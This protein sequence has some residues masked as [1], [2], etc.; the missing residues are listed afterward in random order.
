[1]KV[2][3]VCDDLIQFGGA[4]RVL[5]AV[6]EIWSDA[7]IYTSAAS[8]K[9]TRICKE[10]NID[11]RVS[12]MQRFPFIEK[13]YRY[14]APFFFFCGAFESF[15]L[16]G[17]DVVLSVSSRFAHGVITRPETIHICFMNTPGRMIWETEGYFENESYGYLKPIKRI[18]M[19]FLSPFLTLLRLWDYSAS[20]RVDHF[21]ANAEVS[22][23]RIKKYYQ[24]ESQVIYPFAEMP[25]PAKVR[26]EKGDYFLVIT[27]LNS[28]K[29][30]DIAVKACSSLGLPLKVIGEGPDRQRLE[31]MASSSVSFL[32]YVPE[33]EKVKLILGC[34]ALI[35]TQKEDFGIVPLEVMALGKP[36]IAFGEGGV[37]ETVQPGETGEFYYSQTQEALSEVLK[38]FH[39]SVYLSNVCIDRAGLFSKKNFQN[40]LRDF[41]DEKVSDL[42]NTRR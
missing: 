21:I 12:F 30:V 32:G 23:S 36:V 11:L 15:D 10:E 27:R 5:M 28:W 16:K 19:P 35:Q 6:H 25:D 31:K 8:R 2:A 41:V 18:A 33:E 42:N 39:E 7:P 1:M 37:L 13:A 26:T 38:N 9:W 29:K 14:Y 22:R 20:A 40:N 4:E 34:R 17:Y 3:I 24:R